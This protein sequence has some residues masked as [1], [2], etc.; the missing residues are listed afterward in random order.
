MSKKQNFQIRVA[1]MWAISDFPT[2][3][4][5][6]GQSTARKLACLYSM[7][8]SDHGGKVTQFENH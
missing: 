7:D 3:S 4:M 1:L 5:L 6:Y 8:Y 2:C